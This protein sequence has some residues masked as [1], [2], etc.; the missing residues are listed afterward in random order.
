LVDAA[1]L[2]SS[3]Q[4]VESIARQGL[5]N[6]HD[7]VVLDDGSRFVARTYGWPFA[8]PETIDRQAK[9]VWLL[10]V[11]E[12]AGV[13][14]PQ[15][16]VSVPGAILMRYV[17]GELLGNAPT[18]VRGWADAGRT[19]ALA[20]EIAFARPG[21][22]IAGGVE[23][24]QEG[25]WGSWQI[26]NCE[27]HATRLALRRSD[28]RVDLT[29]IRG[30][31]TKAQSLLDSQ[32]VRLI[33]NDPHPW[34]VLVR[35]GRCVSW[36]DWEFA[37]AAD[38]TWD[39]VRNALFRVTDIGSTP[40]EFYEGYGREPDP[41]LFAIYELAVNLW[42]ANEARYSDR[43]PVTYRAAERY[44]TDLPDRLARLHSLVA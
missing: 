42:M 31:L 20:H 27:R 37:W 8:E 19:L 39:L 35:N 7:V 23:P 16:V 25:S 4:H 32:P 24:F 12:K 38:P 1:G 36:L 10:A 22:V 2:G 28:L 9:E 6:R 13:P 11:L 34:N 14:V 18:D 44:V 29:E 40:K 3:V 5:I 26:A 33:H 41:V 15:V 43:I 17:D 30:V 21:L